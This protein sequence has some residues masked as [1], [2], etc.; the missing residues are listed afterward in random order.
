M[1]CHSAYSLAVIST[2]PNQII[3]LADVPVR[4]TPAIQAHKMARLAE[5][6]LQVVI[7]I[8]TQTPVA[9][10]APAGV[11]TR[12]CPAIRC[13]TP[14]ATEPPY[15]PNLLY[16]HHRQYKTHT[17]QRLNQHALWR[18]LEQL[19]HTLLDPVYLLLSLLKMLQQKHR[20]V[21][22]LLRQ[23]LDYPIQTLYAFY[24]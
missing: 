23:L 9:N 14:R 5:R 12:R 3:D 2:M 21:I 11:H 8:R 6:P 15:I 24:P 20:S 22:R 13:K 17:R 1:P 4:Q 19:L 18:F 10:L 16:N 7:R